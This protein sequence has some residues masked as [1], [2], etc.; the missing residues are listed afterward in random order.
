MF[1]YR[2]VKLYVKTGLFLFY[3]KITITGKENIPKNKAILFVANHQNAMMD[4]L[5][6]AT[7]T[8]KTMYFLARASAF[9]NKIA[10]KLLNA[11]HA[12]AIYR[13]RDGVDSKA[14][15]EV[16]FDR[17]LDLFNQNKSILI[18]PEG[19]HDIKRQ[20][21][22]LRAGFTR[23]TID[24]LLA[25][26]DKDLLI[27]PVGLNY[28]NTINYAKS[29]H[30]IFGKPIHARQFF[31]KEKLNLS[32]ANL[33]NE[34]HYKL[35]KNT[36]HID[37]DNYESK[38]NSLNEKDFLEP[39]ATNIKLKTINFKT[40]SYKLANQKKNFFYYLML[41]NSIF[42]FVIW[43]WLKPK[44]ASVEFISTTKFSLGLTVFPI[45]YTLQ[46]LLVFQFFGSTFALI[47]L[48]L[49]FILVFLSTKTR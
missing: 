28:S 5:I 26:K 37:D 19:S 2:I 12:I 40:K 20:V 9:K 18:F 30:V 44:I 3:K 46:S 41:V 8:N 36:V 24:Y 21:R 27:I 7:A 25:N 42:P 45:F 38:Y 34:V 29:V 31:N 22:S 16:V 17:C 6:V 14:L 10:A 23:M 43:K 49:C 33:I 32:R 47:Y 39:K 1:L 13:V 11:I 15:N 4:P 35:K 48:L